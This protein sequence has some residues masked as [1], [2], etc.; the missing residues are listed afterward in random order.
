MVSW[1]NM[2]DTDHHHFRGLDE[3]GGF[4]TNAQLKFA[5]RVGGDDGGDHLIADGE[6]DLGQQ[7]VEAQL[8]DLADE[9]IAAADRGGELFLLDGGGCS[10]MQHRLNVAFVNAV[11][12]AGSFDGAELAAI[13]P[14]LDGGVRD[15]EALGSIARGV[16]V[17]H[18]KQSIRNYTILDIAKLYEFVGRNA[19]MGSIQC[20]EHACGR[21]LGKE[22]NNDGVPL[23]L[24]RGDSDLGEPPMTTR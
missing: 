10:G 5:R 21:V 22:D 15:A 4:H 13:E 23:I 7:T 14:L 12:A 17:C 8:H 16:E 19:R 24:S 9:L 6:L 3:G 18:R 11:M 1:R 2:S 20:D